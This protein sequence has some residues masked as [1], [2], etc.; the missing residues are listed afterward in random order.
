MAVIIFSSIYP[1]SAYS[2]VHTLSNLSGG[3]G[4]SFSD[5]VTDIVTSSDGTLN[6][7]KMEIRWVRPNEDP[8]QTT[9]ALKLDNR[10]GSIFYP[11]DEIGVWGINTREYG[12]GSNTNPDPKT[13]VADFSVIPAPEFGLLGA[14]SPLLL[15]GLCYFGLRKRMI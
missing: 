15:I 1:V 8:A 12:F 13:S 11:L 14:A 9:Y 4:Y 5:Q 10:Y 7:T 6:G 2:Y 3:T